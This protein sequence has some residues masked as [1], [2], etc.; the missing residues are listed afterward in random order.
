MTFSIIGGIGGFFYRN[1]IGNLLYHY[2]NDVWGDTLGLLMLCM[3]PIGLSIIMGAS[4]M[5]LGKL[6]KQNILFFVGVLMSV[7]LNFILIPKYKSTGAAVAALTVNTIIAIGQTVIFYSVA[8]V[9]AQRL[10]YLKLVI[11]II[12]CLFVFGWIQ[13]INMDI[14]W[15]IQIIMGLIVATLSAFLLGLLPNKLQIMLALLKSRS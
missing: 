15:I 9:K 11:L 12:T 14:S 8:G 10:F 13:Y 5:S 4:I 3:I 2:S 6:K 1:E 7:I